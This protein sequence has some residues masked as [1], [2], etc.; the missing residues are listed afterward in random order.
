[1][2]TIRQGRRSSASAGRFVRR[3]A[4]IATVVLLLVVAQPAR[5]TVVLQVTGPSDSQAGVM[6][7]AGQA[8]AASFTLPAA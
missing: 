8:A 7:S 3:A 5:A 6:M 4:H 2:I 1:M